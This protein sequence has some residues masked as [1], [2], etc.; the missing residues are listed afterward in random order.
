MET[1]RLLVFHVEH[2]MR[3][4]DPAILTTVLLTLGLWAWFWSEIRS[5]RRQYERAVAES[6][7]MKGNNGSGRSDSWRPR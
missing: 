5:A 4:Q 7:L 6:Q 2:W 1:A 3:A